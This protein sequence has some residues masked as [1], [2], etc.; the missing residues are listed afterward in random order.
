MARNAKDR[1]DKSGV[2]LTSHSHVIAQLPAPGTKI[3]MQDFTEV[4]TSHRCQITLPGSKELSWPSQH[5][6]HSNLTLRINSEVWNFFFQLKDTLF[7]ESK[8][9]AATTAS[10]IL[11]KVL[12]E[13]PT[14]RNGKY[15]VCNTN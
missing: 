9:I 11:R 8:S 15:T 14:K 5:L 2:A 6:T 12:Q 1:A 13:K 3:T 10:D 7:K 4:R